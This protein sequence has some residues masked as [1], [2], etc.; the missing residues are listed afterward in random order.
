[1]QIPAH[2]LSEQ[3]QSIKSEI[4]PA[5]QD[6]IDDTDFILGDAVKEFESSFADYCGTDHCIG[7]SSGTAALRLIFEALELGSG[8]EVITTPFTFIATA[9]PLIHCGAKPVFADI[10]PETYNLN[11][12]NVEDAITPDTRALLAVHLYGQPSE[13]D[14][15]RSIADEHDL[16]LIEDA[17]QAHGARWRDKRVGGLGDLGAFSFY[18]GKNLGAFGDA[19]GITTSDPGLAEKLRKLRDHGRDGKYTHSVLGFNFR[20]DGLQGGVL[21]VKLRHLDDWNEGRRQNAAYYNE[22]LSDLPVKTPTVADGAE[23]VYHQYSIRVDNRDN[24][25]EYLNERDIG[26]GVHYPKPLHCQPTFNHLQYQDGDFPESEKASEEVLSLPVYALMTEEQQDHVIEILAEAL[27]E[28][29]TV[30]S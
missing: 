7:V 12:A 26:A 1:M 23:H 28:T 22:R 25:Q 5:L 10:N 4:D 3:Y 14:A 16:H 27:E 30:P 18:P 13:F 11:P 17:A 29:A 8:D 19:G 15:L 2:D 6:I 20:M 21:N 9:E 24:V